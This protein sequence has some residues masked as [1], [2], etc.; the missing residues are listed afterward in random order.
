M[1]KIT[2]IESKIP[3]LPIRKKVAAYAR[4]SME[5]ERLHHSLAAQVSYYSALIQ[6]NPEWEYA[7]VYA[8]EGV[9]GTAASRRSEFMR[10]FADCEAG[11]IDIIL[12][13][14]ISRF[15]RN[16]VDLL[17][18]V[19]HLKDLDIEVRFEKEGINSLSGDGEVMLTLLASFAQEE[20]RSI[21]ENEKWSVK[22]R[23]EQGIPTAR[24]RILGYRWEG[25][26]MVVIPEEAAVVSRGRKNGGRNTWKQD[27]H[28]L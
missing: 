20:I 19:R 11:K 16:T 22:K 26:T 23:F 2:K 12:T 1:G 27:I 28:I 4:V 24:P 25:D 6:N 13:K 5:T 15:A 21:S 9:T 10:M 7:G 3:Q 18:T 8:D 14:S 17:E